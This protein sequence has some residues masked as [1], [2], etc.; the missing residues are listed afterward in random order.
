MKYPK[1]PKQSIKKSWLVLAVAI[2]IGLFAAFIAKQFISKQLD[3]IE[4]RD[5]NRQMVNVVVAKEALNKGAKLGAENLAIRPIPAEYAHSGAVTPDQFERIEGQALAFP[6]KAGEMLMWSALEGR[7]TPTFSARIE[8]GRRA[9]TVPV[10]EINSISGMLEPGDLVD[11]MLTVNQK[12]KKL[13][14]PLLQN[15]TVLATGQ[16]VSNDPQ[17]G[18]KRQYSTMTFDTT[19]EQAQSVIAARELGKITALLRNPNDKSHM[20]SKAD[21]AAILGLVD[22]GTAGA[23]G[24]PVLYGG[25]G[26]LSDDIAKLGV[27]AVPAR[28]EAAINKPGANPAA[29]VMTGTSVAQSG[30]A[31]R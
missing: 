10:D 7:K 16:R 4:A 20:A 15:V 24:V 30:S 23:E 22:G 1:L 25:Q 13:T 14:V 2:G 21:I 28:L 5:K 11:L 8:V 18:E 3:E 27:A 26:K 29:T 6:V 9:M 17:S 19:P 12:N 31:S